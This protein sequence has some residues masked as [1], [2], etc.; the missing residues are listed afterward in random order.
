MKLERVCLGNWEDLEVEASE[1]KEVGSYFARVLL[2]PDKEVF[3]FY[4]MICYEDEKKP[5]QN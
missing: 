1:L 2:T 5:I 3:D 4:S